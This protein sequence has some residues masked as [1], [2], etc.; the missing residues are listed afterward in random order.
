MKRLKETVS[1]LGDFLK[2]SKLGASTMVAEPADMGQRSRLFGSVPS[3]KNASRETIRATPKACR[4]WVSL[5]RRTLSFT[6][7]PGDLGSVQRPL[8]GAPACREFPAKVVNLPQNDNEGLSGETPLLLPETLGFLKG[9]HVEH[10][11]GDPYDRAHECKP[12]AQ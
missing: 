6:P 9:D 4:L 3:W 8:A 7:I 5:S 11:R 1:F 12:D 2:L 10:R